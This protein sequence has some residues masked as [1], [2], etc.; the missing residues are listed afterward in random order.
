MESLYP[1]YGD[2]EKIV[3]LKQALLGIY[4]YKPRDIFNLLEN[5]ECK[6]L[7]KL[8]TQLSLT[9][10]SLTGSSLTGLPSTSSSS[11]YNHNS[12]AIELLSSAT[13]NFVHAS[14]TLGDKYKDSG[15]FKEARHWYKVFIK[16]SPSL[17]KDPSGQR[18]EVI[19]KLGLLLLLLG[20]SNEESKDEKMEENDK[21]DIA[22]ELLIASR[23][24][25]CVDQDYKFLHPYSTRSIFTTMYY[26][27][28]ASKVLMTNQLE[29]K[30]DLLQNI[31]QT[32]FLCTFPEN[33]KVKF[34]EVYG[35]YRLDRDYSIKYVDDYH[36]E[37]VSM[38]KE[39]FYC[40]KRFNVLIQYLSVDV[41]ATGVADADSIS[42]KVHYGSDGSSSLI[43]FIETPL[44]RA[45]KTYVQKTNVYASERRKMLN[46][47]LISSDVTN[48]VLKYLEYD[49]NK[50]SD[51]FFSKVNRDKNSRMETIVK[52]SI[53]IQPLPFVDEFL[54]L[55]WNL[56]SCEQNSMA[57]I[58][59]KKCSDYLSRL[60]L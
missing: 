27:D 4:F 23:Q 13:Q 9:T 31:C 58:W 59:S 20:V 30:E 7:K 12:F 60:E 18:T 5:D 54:L 41:V 52:V 51:C 49:V 48:I 26:N 40:F 6:Y 19:K 53:N 47:Y 10:I 11:E 50:K 25:D 15:K 8:T 38:S 36:N 3:A 33:G 45:L 44:S 43:K 17:Y 35:D 2:S 55:E 1:V 39:K 56:E 46:N 24:N 34:A 42:F 28:K 21:L 22:T 14:K 57:N 32:S 37:K 16:N 29:L